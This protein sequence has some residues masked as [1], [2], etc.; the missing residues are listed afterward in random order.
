[1]RSLQKNQMAWKIDWRIYEIVTDYSGGVGL[2]LN[3]NR[4]SG[5]KSLWGNSCVDEIDT[6]CTIM[7]WTVGS[8]NII[9]SVYSSSAHDTVVRY[10]ND[11]QVSLSWNRTRCL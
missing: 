8:D 11:P 2:H 1:M 9:I 5:Q 4:R 3:E 7:Y 10:T 6:Q